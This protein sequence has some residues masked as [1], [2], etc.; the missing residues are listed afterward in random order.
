MHKSCINSILFL[1]VF[2]LKLCD[3]LEGPCT[4]SKTACS[5]VI[6]TEFFLLPPFSV[7]FSSWYIF[8]VLPSWFIPYF[9][10]YSHYPVV[11][12]KRVY[13]SKLLRACIFENVFD[14]LSNLTYFLPWNTILGW[15]SF[16]FR[17]FSCVCESCIIVKLP[18]LH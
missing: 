6:L 1:K 9:W 13:W 18:K 14:L 16:T 15:K 3:F 2:I 17:L 12:E 8:H 10:W 5:I 11:Y 4:L 7:G